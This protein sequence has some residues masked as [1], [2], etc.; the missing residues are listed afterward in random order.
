MVREMERPNRPLPAPGA[1][2][3]PADPIRIS[4]RLWAERLSLELDKG[5]RRQAAEKIW[6]AVAHAI[7]AL[8]QQRGW[9]TGKTDRDLEDVVVQL[10]AELDAA[11][12]VPAD[13]YAAKQQRFRLL[14][15]VVNEIHD[16][17]NGFH[18]KDLDADDIEFA[19]GD[20]AEL[21]SHLEPLLDTPPQ[22]YTP[23]PGKDQRRLARLLGMPPPAKND[24]RDL[25]NR[26]RMAQLNRWFP[27]GK[28]DANGFSPACGYRKPET[29]EYDNCGSSGGESSFRQPAADQRAGQGRPEVWSREW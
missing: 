16:K 2:P 24:S 21:L 13:G 26:E 25:E 10:G 11:A 27:P 22:P 1:N 6:G 5:S 8:G 15:S 20:A 23:R 28:T 17:D 4:R 18:P 12:G 29:T 9:K 19:A 3:S 7:I 14:L